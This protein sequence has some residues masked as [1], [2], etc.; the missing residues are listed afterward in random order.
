[1]LHRLFAAFDTFASLS[2]L[3]PLVR[4][5]WGD[6]CTPIDDECNHMPPAPCGPP[7]PAAA[8]PPPVR[9]ARR[10]TK[11]ALPPNTGP[12]PVSHEPPYILDFGRP[13]IPPGDKHNV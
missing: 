1:M 10:P 6:A 5:R 7:Q 4:G 11:P 2:P 3:F 13:T 8:L 12:A 9:A